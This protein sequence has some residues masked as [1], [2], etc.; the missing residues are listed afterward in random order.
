MRFNYEA[1]ISTAQAGSLSPLHVTARADSAGYFMGRTGF[2][3]NA[4]KSL[5]VAWVRAVRIL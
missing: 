5:I 3:K 2:I 4:N 1:K